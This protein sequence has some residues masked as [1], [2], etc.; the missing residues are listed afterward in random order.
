MNCFKCKIGDVFFCSGEKYTLNFWRRKEKKIVMCNA[1][2][3]IKNILN[4][5]ITG[6]TITTTMCDNNLW[7]YVKCTWIRVKYCH[8]SFFDEIFNSTGILEV[9]S[10]TAYN[11]IC[12]NFK[13]C[14][15]INKKKTMLIQTVRCLANFMWTMNKLNRSEVQ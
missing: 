13:S 11:L 15:F 9:N 7:L 10:T 5:D 14:N 1:G 3:D 2:F 4:T 12:V 8:N 6:L